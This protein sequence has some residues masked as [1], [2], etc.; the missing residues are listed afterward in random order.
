MGVAL[1][2]WLN[3]L[4]ALRNAIV[5]RILGQVEGELT[6]AR[7]LSDTVRGRHDGRAFHLELRTR[8]RYRLFARSVDRGWAYVYPLEVE[9]EL[10]CAP[11]LELRVRR[12]YPIPRREPNEDPHDPAGFLRRHAVLGEA[13]FDPLRTSREARVA[14]ARLLGP[15]GLEEVSLREG[16]LHAVGRLLKVGPQELGQILAELEVLAREFDRR[17]ALEIGVAQ[18]YVWVGAD[19]RQAR[20]AYC[21]DDLGRDDLVSCGRCHTL[22]HADCYAEHGGCPILGC[23]GHQAAPLPSLKDL[24]PLD[25]EPGAPPPPPA[26]SEVRLAAPPLQVSVRERPLD[27]PGGAFAPPPPPARVPSGPLAAPPGFLDPAGYPAPPWELPPDEPALELPP[28]EPAL[29]LPPDEPPLELPPEDALELPPDD[30]GAPPLRD[31]PAPPE[32]AG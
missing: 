9:I 24:G 16:R 20:C 25:L 3:H 14:L 18:R 12:I 31:A 5:V 21:H 11:P 28:D 13:G 15:C 22:T 1:W 2:L 8:A 27:V 4:R 19:D 32:R 10:P 7:L 23:G 6:G 26:P 17:P 29:E 30:L